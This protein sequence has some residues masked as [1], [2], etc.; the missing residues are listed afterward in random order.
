MG[1]LSKKS[2][3]IGEKIAS[4]LLASLGWK[5][6]IHNV[7]IKCNTR[8][9]VNESGNQR[10]THGED[11]IFICSSPFHDNRTDIV[12]IS[13]KNHIQKYPTESSLKSLFKDHIKE[14][15]ETIECAKHSPE[16]KILTTG[17]KKEKSHSGL[18]IWLQEDEL[19]IEHNIKPILANTQLAIKSKVPI[20]LIDNHRASFL[21]NIIED[22]KGRSEDGEVNFWYPKI[23]TALSVDENRDGSFLPLELIASDIVT[24][25][26]ETQHGKEMIIYANQ[27]FGPEAYRRLIAYGLHFCSGLINTIRIGM[28]DYNAANDD[29]Q[30][31]EARF[32]FPDRREKIIPF[33]YKKTFI[34]LLGESE[35]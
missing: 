23:G 30:A 6:S 15:H 9:H 31:K 24:A 29:F 18:L 12:H 22:L 34:N 19:D 1:E 2:G 25:T 3:E 33:S 5:P 28:P 16:L 26:V 32:A 20:Y 8:G 4:A 35:Q 13:K 14:L 10:V 7:S 17:A 21:F 11:E 27:S